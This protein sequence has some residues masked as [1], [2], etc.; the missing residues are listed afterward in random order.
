MIIK[1][2]FDHHTVGTLHQ[3]A[4]ARKLKALGRHLPLMLAI[5]GILILIP[6]A[7]LL[8]L[9]FGRLRDEDPSVALAPLARVPLAR[10]GKQYAMQVVVPDT[11]QWRRIRRS[12]GEPDLIVAALSN[13]GGAWCLADLAT[14]VDVTS[15][16]T[17]I[18]LKRA[19]AGYGH[20]GDCELSS[21]T[22]RA[23]P[24]GELLVKVTKRDQLPWPTGDLVV[25]CDWRNT[26]DKLV[27]ISIENDLQKLHPSAGAGAIIGLLLLA[28]ASDLRRW[29]R[30]QL[31]PKASPRASS[32]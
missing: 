28:L 13:E 19:A 11:D 15:R 31:S 23:P 4:G 26:K 29:H 20:A 10:V 27:G 2:S 14:A 12:W 16:G 1:G 5:L 8:G 7:L 21:F 30:Q 25:R 9:L 32:W 22:F 17:L 18:P 6:S 24:A 3:R